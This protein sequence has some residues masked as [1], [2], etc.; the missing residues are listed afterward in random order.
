MTNKAEP[1]RLNYLI[2]K[3]QRGF[4]ISFSSLPSSSFGPF[5]VLVKLV[6]E[7]TWFLIV[8]SRANKKNILNPIENKEISKLYIWYI[9]LIKKC[10]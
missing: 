9:F 2:K 1:I 3:T 7:V 6:F 4:I 8:L 10:Y 5:E